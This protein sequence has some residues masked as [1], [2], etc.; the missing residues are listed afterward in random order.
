MPP[1]GRLQDAAE[2]L[3]LERTAGAQS[4]AG[5]RIVGYSDGQTGLVAKDFVEP[6][7]KCAAASEND[8]L[9][10]NIG[11]E[12]RSRV[13]ERDSHALDDGSDGL[14]QRFGDLPLVDRDLL[15]DAVDQ[16]AP[17]DV[18][19]LAYAIDRRLSDPEN[20]FNPLGRRSA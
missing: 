15:R 3:F 13:L 8:A 16:V 12:L 17:L 19:G 14:R 1:L 11:G 18:H 5:Q 7:Q 2:L 4:N 10:A 20:H 9:I 6:L